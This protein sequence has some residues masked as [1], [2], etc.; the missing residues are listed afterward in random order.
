MSMPIDRQDASRAPP[1]R[2]KDPAKRAAILEAAT[3]LFVE[4]GFEGA[5]MD[6]I[7]TRA[8]VSKLT[9]YSHFGDKETLFVE[10]VEHYC[11]RQVPPALF[12]PAPGTPLRPRLLGL[13]RAVH[14]LMASP[15]AIS[16]YR[17]MC[18]SRPS[19]SRLPEMFWEAGA[20]RLQAGFAALLARR[21]A[22]GDLDI[23]DPDRASC[24]FFALLRGDLHPRLVMGCECP[25]AQDFEPHIEAC[26]DMF[27]R[28]YA[29]PSVR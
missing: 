24:Q 28:A 17:L 8:G 23:T 25:P 19:G 11:G 2:P 26:V 4:H 14:A 15:E 20:G 22:A 27:L 10:S 18:S 3:T 16:G 6:Q 7:A 29:S 13:A 9:V 21:T 5:S 12:E 1:G